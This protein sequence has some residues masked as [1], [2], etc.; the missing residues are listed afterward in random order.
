MARQTPRKA[1]A[2]KRERKPLTRERV[3][4]EGLRFVDREGVDAL[5]MQKLGAE[6]GVQAMSLYEYVESKDDLFSGIAQLLLE[7]LEQPQVVGDWEA[8]LR[9]ELAAWARMGRD[10]PNAFPLLFRVRTLT[11]RDLLP[12]ERIVASL[13]AAG[14]DD[15]QAALA[16]GAIVAFVDG[17][18]LSMQGFPG[19]VDPSWRE[20]VESHAEE[21]P[22]YLEMLA[23]ARQVQ[24]DDVFECGVD[25]LVLG[26]RE[27]LR[28]TDLS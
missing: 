23:Y 13:R 20:V 4:E 28:A 5:T 14:F 6:L 12:H 10:H 15:A 2:G 19:T 16:W 8:D 21:I 25:L 22:N 27:R 7:E 18:L 11:V 17:F 24:S 9:A 3:L 26:L 1:R